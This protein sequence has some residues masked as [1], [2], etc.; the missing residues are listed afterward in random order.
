MEEQRQFILSGLEASDP[1]VRYPIQEFLS[2]HLNFFKISWWI[3]W[4]ITLVVLSY[5]LIVYNFIQHKKTK[6]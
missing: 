6:D 1:I 3:V 4:A 5:R 2:A